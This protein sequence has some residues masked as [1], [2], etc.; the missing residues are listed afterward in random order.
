MKSSK[1]YIVWAYPFQSNSGGV[2]V[3]H[4]LCH[5]LNELGQKAYLWPGEGSF[6]NFQ[7]YEKYN[8]PMASMSDLT[9][10]IIIYP[11]IVVGNPLNAKN[12]V[13]WILN[14]P[15]VIGGDGIYGENDL[16]FYF[17]KAFN[18][19][20]RTQGNYLQIFEMNNAMYQDYKKERTGSC[21]VKRKGRAR[22]L[23]HDLLESEEITNTSPSQELV[24][25]FNKK[26][27][28]FSYDDATFL[29]LQAAMCGCISVVIPKDGVTPYHWRNL[30]P[31]RKTGIAYG[32]DDIEHALNTKENVRKHLE[33][34]D[35]FSIVMVQEFI[36]RSQNHFGSDND[37]YSKSV[38][39]VYNRS[40]IELH[41]NNLFEAGEIITTSENYTN[42][43]NLIECLL[44]I[45]EARKQLHTKNKWD[46]QIS[47]AKLVEC[48]SLIKSN[49]LIQ[50]GNVL[51]EILNAE[52]NS[53]DALNNLAVVYILQ[54]NYSDAKHTLHNVLAI[55]STN[56][57]ALENLEYLQQVESEIPIA[58]P[59]PVGVAN[60]SKSSAT[61]ELIRKYKLDNNYQ[62][63]IGGGDFIKVGEDL[64]QQMIKACDISRSE[65]ILDI[66]S[67]Y[68][69]VALPFSQYLDDGGEYCGLEIVKK[70]VDWCTEVIT[71]QKKN[72]KF[73]HADVYNF[74]Y[75]PM[76]S[77]K[78][79]FYK[80]P[81]ESNHFDF[82][83]LT[84]V[85]THM[86]SFELDNYLSEISRCL[87][88]GGRCFITYFIMNT[89]SKQLMNEKQS[90]MYFPHRIGE[91]WLKDVNDPEAAVCFDESFL[92]DLY[93]KHGLKIELPI[94][95]GQWC[96][97]K[98]YF[99]YQDVIIGTKI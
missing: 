92:I 5:M 44:E 62:N 89:E 6:D 46:A 75:N 88:S 56:D 35:A 60:Q 83:L 68:G 19:N 16:L 74:H 94:K 42:E 2:I 76:G 71:S 20:K 58:V 10:S 32:F 98:T 69:R 4:K 14:T 86:L 13:R 41:F 31:T 23:V 25:L 53:C 90:A 65:K 64:M 9:D 8:T 37:N 78:A 3:L 63:A 95:Y 61:E 96:G 77:T 85:F 30:S 12:V 66:G 7:L 39:S 15:G 79:C 57:I 29:L 73:L 27:Y 84:S 87:K 40:K 70:E 45:E 21:Y 49:N 26:E 80:M 99:D 93:K 54:S 91:F 17:S 47:N 67:G 34:L 97:R 24:D 28:F 33:S 81:L 82:V 52:P 48:E 36:D 72:F 51:W 50:A 55:D 22:E 1:K 18:S 38:K 59:Q 43:T 11:E